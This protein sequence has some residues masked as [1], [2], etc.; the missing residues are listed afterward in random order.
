MVQE[1]HNR[2]SGINNESGRPGKGRTDDF[3]RETYVNK[4]VLWQLSEQEQHSV[5]TSHWFRELR[6]TCVRDAGVTSSRVLSYHLGSHIRERKGVNVKLI[7]IS[8]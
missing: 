2:N 6:H 3:W 5:I 1:K 7:V 4:T 8:L